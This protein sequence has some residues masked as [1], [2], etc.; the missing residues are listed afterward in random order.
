MAACLLL[1]AFHRLR[2]AV[3]DSLTFAPAGQETGLDILTGRREVDFSLEG[4]ADRLWRDGAP[5]L[6]VRGER[7]RL[8][9]E[10]NV[11]YPVTIEMTVAVAGGTAGCLALS[12][13]DGART[14]LPLPP[15]P[16]GQEPADP[17]A[18]QAVAVTLAA[19]QGRNHVT[20]DFLPG[21][22][23][24]APA[25]DETVTAVVCGV[26]SAPGPLAV[27][28]DGRRTSRPGLAGTRPNAPVSAF[29]PVRSRIEGIHGKAKTRLPRPGII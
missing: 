7:L 2:D 23:G 15:L 16:P 4:R 20:I 29:S 18:G 28:P 27:W 24:G 3:A 5:C 6:V 22:A 21:P 11:R 14:E 12:L 26:A 8:L 9:F 1:I 10:L 25:G 19:R 17:G 13:N